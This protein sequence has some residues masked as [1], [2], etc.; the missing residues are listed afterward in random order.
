MKVSGEWCSDLKV[1]AKDSSASAWA[2][3][4]HAML[5]AIRLNNMPLNSCAQLHELT[6]C[7]NNSP[8]TSKTLF[9]NIS[10]NVCVFS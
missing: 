9:I 7:K 10:K 3:V 1:I 5:R 8:N 2:R 4:M 6:H